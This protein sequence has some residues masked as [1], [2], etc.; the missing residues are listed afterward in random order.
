[1]P[2]INLGCCVSEDSGLPLFYAACPGPIVDKSRLTRMM[3]RNGELGISKNVGFVLGRGFCST[4]NVGFLVKA[5]HG[6]IL[7]VDKRNEEYYEEDE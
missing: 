2:Q 4:A 1:L 3:A 6:F 5:G 7:E